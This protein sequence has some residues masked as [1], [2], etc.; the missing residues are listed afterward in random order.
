MAKIKL[1]STERVVSYEQ[2]TS[3]WII[4]SEGKIWHLSS[5]LIPS[6]TQDQAAKYS[7]K[8]GFHV[9]SVP[10]HFELFQAMYALRNNG[11]EIEKAR[12]FVQSSMR[13]NF[14]G[15]LTRIGHLS[16]G[17]DNIIHNYKTSFEKKIKAKL[18]GEDGLAK[19]VLSSEASLA[20][21]GKKP[22]EVE[23]LLRYIDNTPTFVLRLNSKPSAK[24]ERA[25]AF[26]AG[27]GGAL[28]L[29]YRDPRGSYSWLGVC[30]LCE[31]P[32]KIN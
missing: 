1:P 10:D 21:T 2:P 17:K 20:L 4:P 8:E 30:H 25:V 31:A 3:Y 6:M 26:Y 15:T 23:E 18:V 16:K 7:S 9:L 11:G 32:Q 29:C 22:E 14:L 28:L 27:S 13:N 5:E 19:Y 24:D 12:A